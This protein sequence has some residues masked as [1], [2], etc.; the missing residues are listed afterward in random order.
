MSHLL[1]IYCLFQTRCSQPRV[2]KVNQ[3]WFCSPG[4]HSLVSDLD[5]RDAEGAVVTER[6][7]ES[8]NGQGKASLKRRHL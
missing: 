8:A 3:A 6:V 1:N 5:D 7:N 4:I 2:K